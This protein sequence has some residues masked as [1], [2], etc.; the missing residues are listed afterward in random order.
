MKFRKFGSITALVLSTLTGHV[1]TAEQE[2]LPTEKLVRKS[3]VQRYDPFNNKLIPVPPAEIKPGFL[4]RHYSPVQG[5]D[6]WSLANAQGGFSY[7]MGQGSI[8]PASRLDIRATAQKTDQVLRELAPRWAGALKSF[9]APPLIILDKND[10]W[11]LLQRS[12]VP[13]VMDLDTGRRW[14][15]QGNR[16][17]AVVHTGGYRWEVVNGRYVPTAFNLPTVTPSCALCSP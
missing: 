12:S 9:G 10:Q 17:V 8:Q 5:R 14:E 1:A 4:Y 15:W 2:L 11:T 13:Q 6:V 16:Q 7:A 3:L